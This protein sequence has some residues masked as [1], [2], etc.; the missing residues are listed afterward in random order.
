MNKNKYLII[1]VFI[2]LIL[3]SLG[4]YLLS[5][6]PLFDTF[7]WFIKLIYLFSLIITF[8]YII[9]IITKNKYVKVNYYLGLLFYVMFMIITLYF[10]DTL[11]VETK[12]NSFYLDKWLKIIFSNRIVFLNL[13]GNILIFIPFG[14][15]LKQF[16]LPLSIKLILIFIIIIMLELIQYVTKKGVFDYLDIALNILG[17]FI[18][19]IFC[20]KIKEDLYYEKSTIE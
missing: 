1:L 20:K 18:G 14:I 8:Q 11:E 17:T 16:D 2:Y 4:F 6:I 19:Y 13:I 7:P 10:R 9:Y 5:K 15:F 12:A 3:I